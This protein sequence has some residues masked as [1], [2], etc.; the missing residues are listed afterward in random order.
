[1]GILF[2]LTIEIRSQ[3]TL[4]IFSLYKMAP[5]LTLSYERE[6]ACYR[7]MVL[8]ISWSF[9]VSHHAPIKFLIVKENQILETDFHL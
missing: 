7:S 5:H 2:W 3:G 6:I 8:I 1:M 4:Q 9:P